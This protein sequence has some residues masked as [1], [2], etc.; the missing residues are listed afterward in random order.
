MA[1]VSIRGAA[2][3]AALTW[4]AT[5]LLAACAGAPAVDPAADLIRPNPALLVSAD[6]VQRWHE[7]KDRG[8]PT[9]SGNPSWRAYVE[10]LESR[11]RDA[12]VVGITRNAWTYDRWSTTEWPDTSGWS[13]VSNGSTVRVSHY[14]AN[15]GSTGPEGI[16][17][18]LALYTPTT[19]ASSL[20]G[21]IVVFRTAPHPKPPLDDEYKRWFTMND[22]EYASGAERFPPMYAQ[23]P[24]SETVSYDVWWQLRQTAMVNRVLSESQAAGGVVVFDMSHRRLAGLYTFP[25]MA[26]H[27]HPTLYVDRVAGR[28]LIE[29]ARAGRTATLTLRARVEPAETWQLIGYLPGRDYGTEADEKILMVSHTDGPAV[30]QDNGAL[31]ILA[32]VDYFAKIPRRH[33]P[34]TLMVY[35]DNRHYMPGMEAAFARRDWLAQHPQARASIVGLV[36][37]EHLGQIEFREVGEVYEPT[38]QVEPAFLWTRK[39]P[40]LIAAAIKAVQDNGWDRVIVQSVERPGRQGGMQGV[41]YGMGRIALD[42]NVPAFATM[43]TQGAYWSTA[44]RIDTFDRNQFRTEAAAMVQLTGTLMTLPRH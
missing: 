12:G 11:L 30:L 34:R 39:D 23:V 32:V 33:R 6:E 40:W 13:L 31:G 5:T 36:A 38:G 35:L 42:L 7:F 21:K 41:W 16:T 17:A 2:H 28:S 14:G 24:A 3:R 44:A 20:K 9:F 37:M 25:V 19:P 15:S 8:G 22:Y 43:G 18:Q 1:S 26:L 4:C 29:D 10:F 27:N